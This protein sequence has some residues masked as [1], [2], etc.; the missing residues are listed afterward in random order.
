MHADSAPNAF[1][2]SSIIIADGNKFCVKFFLAEILTPMAY[3]DAI[4]ATGGKR[5]FKEKGCCNPF[6]WRQRY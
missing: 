1:P 6:C 4:K 3:T 5:W 2:A